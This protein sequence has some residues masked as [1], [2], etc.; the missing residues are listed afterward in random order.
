MKKYRHIFFDL[1]RTLWD[2]DASTEDSFNK[3]FARYGLGRL[4]VPS[5]QAFRERYEKHND[6]LWSWYIRG[7]I[8]KEVLN[9]RRFE[10][11]L[12]DFGIHDSA[13]AIGMSEDYVRVDPARPFLFPGAL[14]ALEYLSGK[15]LL[16][17][18]TNGF[19][20]VQEQKFRIARL[21]RYFSTVTT[22]EEACIKKPEPEI[23]HYAMKKAGAVAPESIIIGD[24]LA[25]DIAG[26]RA[27]G[28]D[29]VYFNPG[30]KTHNDKVTYE[31]ASL[32]ELQDIF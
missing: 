5:L 4:G 28:M 15:C 20:E 31:I 9:I 26:A 2:F 10:M 1:D 21:S 6:M 22:S 17:L 19:A 11:T 32:T 7:N 16:H 3:M 27:V 14:E 30:R 8:L 18:I 23:F 29:Q 13:I 25:V 24:D 12:A